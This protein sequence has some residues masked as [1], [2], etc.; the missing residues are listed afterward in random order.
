MKTF[1]QGGQLKSLMSHEGLPD[2]LNQIKP[3]FQA[4]FGTEFKGTLLN[5]LLVLGAQGEPVSLSLWDDNE[6]VADLP[7]PIYE[8]LIACINLRSPSPVFCSFNTQGSHTALEPGVQYRNRMAARGVEFATFRTLK[9]NAQILYK[10]HN[11]SH[12]LA[13]QIQD[14]FV[15]RRPGP[16]GRSV[17]EVFFNVR[18]YEELSYDEARSDPYRKH[19]LLDVRLCHD[20]LSTEVTVVPLDGVVSHYASCSVNVA[21][22]EGNVKVILSLDWVSGFFGGFSAADTAQD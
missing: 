10:S 14:I 9:G 19:P 1:C 22:I 8:Q 20:K 15:H 12:T 18:H 17:S 4:N 7:L 2:I 13:G 3:A 11:S 16:N 5:D 21:G 6:K